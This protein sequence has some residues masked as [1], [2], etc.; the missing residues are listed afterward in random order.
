[1][2]VRWEIIGIAVSAGLLAGAAAAW[3]VV[4]VA[5]RRERARRAR[6][7][8]LDALG[9]WLAARLNLSRSAKS[10]L[11]AVRSLSP[12]GE[13]SAQTVVRVEELTRARAHW[14]NAVDHMRSAECAILSRCD[15]PDV[16]VRLRSLGG[17]DVAR[18]R[19]AL[20]GGDREADRFLGT[21]KAI[22][23]RAYEIVMRET[24][25]AGPSREVSQVWRRA[26]ELVELFRSIAAHWAS[27]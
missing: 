21:L 12:R 6:E 2:V 9:A 16:H 17:V 24:T 8:L 7:R 1:M 11:T 13:A 23:E 18:L 5:V 25:R 19:G 27:P 22:D 15:D 26:R 20:N 3:L 4:T 14:H 10:L